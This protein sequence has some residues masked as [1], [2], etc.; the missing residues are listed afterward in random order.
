M[1]KGMTRVLIMPL[2]TFAEVIFLLW[3]LLFRG[4]RHSWQSQKR[5]LYAA[6]RP[7]KKCFGKFIDKGKILR[8]FPLI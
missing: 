7:G 1:T 6:E 8:L 5:S 2:K 3:I 4:Q